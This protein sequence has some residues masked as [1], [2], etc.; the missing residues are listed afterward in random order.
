MKEVLGERF[1]VLQLDPRD[2]IF[3][4][5]LP[6]ALKGKKCFNVP[7][8]VQRTASRCKRWMFNA[9]IYL[10]GFFCLYLKVLDIK[11]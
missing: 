9:K 5:Y 7:A 3:H 6:V 10:G 11:T 1:E 8:L 2:H 4:F